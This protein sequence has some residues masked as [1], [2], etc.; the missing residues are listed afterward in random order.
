METYIKIP[1]SVLNRNISANSKILYSKLLLLSHKKGYCFA[2]NK[3]LGDMLK[4]STRTI[5]KLISELKN[6]E[7]IL[8]TYDGC[9]NR[10]IFLKKN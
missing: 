1:D 9:H 6:E 10:Q 4:V 2:S 7:L 8:T 5:T 3:Y